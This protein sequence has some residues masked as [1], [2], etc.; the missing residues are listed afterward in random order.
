MTSTADPTLDSGA[1]LRRRIS[2]LL[3]RPAAPAAFAVAGVVVALVSQFAIV[4]GVEAAIAAL[5]FVPAVLLF[6]CAALALHR[7]RVEATTVTPFEVSRRWEI[8][9]LVAIIALAAFF[10]FFR[11]TE[12]PPGLWYD[13]AVNGADAM[14]II[15][16]GHLTVWR[17]SNFG[18]STLYFYLLIASF[19]TFGFTVFAFRLVPALAGMAAVVAFYALARWLL[20]AVPALVATALLAV[21]RYAVT[22]S[23]ISWEA[24]LQPLLE[25]MAVFFLVRA[26]ETKSRFYFFMAGG[27]LA[28]GI[29]TYLGF[30]FVPVVMLFFLLY[31][32]ATQWR[33]LRDNVPGLVIYAVSFA[34][35]IAPLGQFAIRHQDLFLERTRE[36]NV[37][38]QIDREGSW[39]PL[40]H[41]VAATVKMMNVAGDKNGRHNLPGAPMLDGI[42]AALLVLGAAA[43]VWSIRNWRW[44]SVFGWLVLAVVPG[45]LTISNEN[46]SAI[47][48]I[49]AIP[50][51]FLLTGLAVAVLYQSMSVTRAGTMLF[52]VAAL[53]MVGASAAVNYHEFFDEQAHSQAVYDAF[54]AAID[55]HR[56]DDRRSRRRG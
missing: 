48:D 40:R 33:L 44:G 34:I 9:A 54:H 5:G 42:S 56:R 27:S 36:I 53:A 20:G 24:S 39:A 32:A 46:P 49:G 19:K 23:R 37:F 43:S 10:R 6:G 12:F 2:G 11:F 25:I 3:D 31:I 26:L 14:W 41:N 7:R 47:R 45:A 1:A 50:P 35:V 4:A 55:A 30:R 22:F 21:S 38:N 8:A 18:H 16:H 51:L 52:G 28:A 13:E 29:Y 15:D 17:S